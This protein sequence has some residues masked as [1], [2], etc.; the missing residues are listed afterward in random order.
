M[1]PSTWPLHYKK[2][3][4]TVI[5]SKCVFSTLFNVE[6]FYK[7]FI[8]DE[9]WKKLNF[10]FVLKKKIVL[11]WLIFFVGPQH[12]PSLSINEWS[13]LGLFP[14]RTEDPVHATIVR[15]RFSNRKTIPNANWIDGC[16][17]VLYGMPWICW[18]GHQT[19]LLSVNRK[20]ISYTD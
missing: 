10:F 8:C 1:T 19:N 15:K 16:L 3:P 11:I 13:R 2:N 6:A 18:F 20:K 5:L 7:K 14:S 4:N 9:I 17:A 12:S